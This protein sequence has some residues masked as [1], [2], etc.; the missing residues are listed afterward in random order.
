MVAAG[1]WATDDPLGLGGLMTDA[2]RL[3]QIER[4]GVG[5]DPALLPALLNDARTGLKHL[6]GHFT[7]RSPA[8]QR[9]AFRELGLAIGLAAM[10]RLRSRLDNRDRRRLASRV[11]PLAAERAL[12][13]RIVEFWMKPDHQQ[14]RE[15][16]RPSGHQ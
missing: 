10:E 5:V 4:L 13:E 6:R 16:D 12:G 2:Y 8:G 1:R 3:F 9:L 11:E 7:W 15:L 14:V